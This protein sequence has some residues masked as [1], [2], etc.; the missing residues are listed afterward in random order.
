MIPQRSATALPS[1][2]AVQSAAARTTT[3]PRA[4]GPLTYRVQRGDTLFSIA[5]RF[6]TTVDAIKRMNRLNSNIINI[7]ARLTVR[8]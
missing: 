8:Q 3:P 4:T 5:Q 1:P 7:G 6:S 2:A